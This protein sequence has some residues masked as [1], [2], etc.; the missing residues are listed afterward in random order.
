MSPK[1]DDGEFLLQTDDAQLKLQNDEERRFLF[2]RGFRWG[3]EAP[4]NR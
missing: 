4:V 2:D 1:T 3:P